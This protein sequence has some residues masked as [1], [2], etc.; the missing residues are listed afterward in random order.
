MATA[1]MS[2]NWTKRGG[3]TKFRSSPDGSV[4]DLYGLE[5]AGIDSAVMTYGARLTLLRTPDRYGNM[6]DVIL[7]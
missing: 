1:L 7:N 4:V 6:E 3:G 5:N 2:S